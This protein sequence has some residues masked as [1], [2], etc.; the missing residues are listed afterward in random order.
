MKDWRELMVKRGTDRINA[1]EAAGGRARTG[2]AAARERHRRPAIPEPSPPGGR[3]TFRP[4][5]A[6]CTPAPATSRPWLA[7]CPMPSRRSWRYPDRPVFAFVGDGGFT[8]L[9]GELATCVKYK[10]PIRI[11]VIKNNSLGQIK[12]EQMVFLGN[13]EYVCDLQPIDF[14][15]V[16]RGFGVASFVIDDPRKCGT[17]LD[18]ALATDGPVLIEA[19]VDPNTPPD[20]REDQGG[21]GAASCGGSCQRDAGRERHH[22]GHRRRAGP[23]TRLIGNVSS[24]S[25]ADN[26]LESQSHHA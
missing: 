25:K 17:T 3:G 13:P 12:W 23:R 2:Q 5:A 8:M 7:A 16:A 9:M 22:Q 18:Q 10:L 20:A 21:A 26:L 14:A 4:S 24:R 11:V 15:A 1:D 6:R 19:V